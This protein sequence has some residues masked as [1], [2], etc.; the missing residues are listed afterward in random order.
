MSAIREMRPPAPPRRVALLPSSSALPWHAGRHDVQP[1]EPLTTLN[2]VYRH[3][4]VL[5]FVEETEAPFVSCYLDLEP[6]ERSWRDVLEVR[7]RALRASF[8]GNKQIDFEAAMER[9]DAY[10]A[11]ELR[12]DARGVALFSRSVLGGAFFLPMQFAVPL[13]D[14]IHVGPTPNLFYLMALL[15]TYD[16]Y[17]VLIATRLS[18]RIFEVDL[19]AAHT[20][21]WSRRPQ[22]PSRRRRCM[23]NTLREGGHRHAVAQFLD[24]QKDLL[25]R[26]MAT[27]RHTHLILA[28]EP[29]HTGEI[30]RALPEWLAEKVVD[31]IPAAPHH[32]ADDVMAAAMSVFV[33]WEEQESQAIAARIVEE[34]AQWMSAAG[35]P[36]CLSALRQRRV[37]VLLVARDHSP[38]PA[39][40]CAACGTM[41]VERDV[42]GVCPECGNGTV[43]RTDTSAELTRLAAQR[44]SPIEV[45]DHCDVLMGAGGVACLWRH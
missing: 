25:V 44:G 40:H 18:V 19:G 26:I 3:V 38:A 8:A 32:A 20:R 34:D 2:E 23:A 4:S 11:T 21:G 12:P 27:G 29:R 15:D 9:I 17:V 10:L 5:A 43:W 36:D 13:P 37:D 14:S 6:G 35:A 1:T 45:V 28:G 30:R 16:R 22:W 24:E 7:T 39:W 33:E 41:R 42:P 31:T